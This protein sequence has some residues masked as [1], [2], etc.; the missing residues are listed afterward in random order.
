MA[1]RQKE[2]ENKNCEYT[3]PE[4]S[5]QVKCVNCRS[6]ISRWGRRRPAEVLER[7]RKLRLYD[8]RL[9]DILE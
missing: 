8:T 2:C 3:L 7:R 9:D 1:K 6:A 4:S 5:A